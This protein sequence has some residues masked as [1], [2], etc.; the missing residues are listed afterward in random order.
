MKVNPARALQSS[1]GGAAES[2][3][4]ISGGLRNVPSSERSRRIGQGQAWGAP[5]LRLRLEEAA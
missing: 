1:R 5:E 4:G 3:K 2:Q